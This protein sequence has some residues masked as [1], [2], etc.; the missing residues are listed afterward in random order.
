MNTPCLNLRI[1]DGSGSLENG[2]YYAVIAYTIKGEKISDY[3]AASNVQPVYTVNTAQGS[4]QL[5]VEADAEN[6]DEFQLVLVANINENTVARVIGYYS[7]NTRN[8]FIDQ[9]KPSFESIDI[10]LIPLVTPV[11]EKSD[12]I[13]QLNT[14]LLRVG[15]TSRFDFNY[16]PLAN[17]IETE[18]VSVEY[19]ANYYFKGGS[20]TN[21]MRD[22]VY[23]FFIRWVYNTGDKSAS[24]HIPGRAPE[25]W[26]PNGIPE[27]EPYSNSDSFP[28]DTLLFQT[29][30]T[31]RLNPAFVPYTLPDGGRVIAAGKMGYWQS[32]EK[33][34]DNRPDIWNSSSYVWTGTWDT[35]TG[36]PI[37]SL[38]YDLCGLPIRHHK[39][40]ENVI[41]NENT[42][43]LLIF[44]GAHH[45]AKDTVTKAIYIRMMSV[46]FKNIIYPKDNDGNDIPGIVGYE[47]LRGSRDGNRSII[48]KGMINNFRTYNRVG[49]PGNTRTGL[50]ANYPYNT[51][52]PIG[53]NNNP[54]DHNYLYNDP[55]IKSVDANNNFLDQK[56]PKN[57]ISFHSPDTS[58]RT[59]YLAPIELKIYGHLEGKALQRF[60]EP[61]GHPKF[62]LM[63]NDAL[64]II[65]LSGLGDALLRRAGKKQINYPL[66]SFENWY[67]LNWA[68]T[69]GSGGPAATFFDGL[70]LT[71]EL[72]NQYYQV[73][74]AATQPSRTAFFNYV[75]GGGSLGDYFLGTDGQATIA[76]SN[77]S[78]SGSLGGIRNSASYTVEQSGASLLP[79]WTDDLFN[80]LSTVT[81]SGFYFMEGAQAAQDLIQAFI[82]YRQYALQLIG[83]GLYDEFRPFNI[84]DTKRFKIADSSYVFKNIS[85]EID[86]YNDTIIG[87][88]FQK[89]TINNYKRGQLLMLRTERPNTP[90]TDG[91]KLLATGASGLDQSLGSL[92]MF[93]DT[94]GPD[95]P[96]INEKKKSIEFETRIA[97]HYGAMKID[98]DDQYGQLKTITQFPITPCEQKFDY[99][100]L[101]STSTPI[102]AI[103]V[104]V[105]Q[106]IITQ[107]PVIFGGDTYITRF[108]EKNPM[109]FFYNWLYTEPNGYEYNY[110]NSQMIPEPRYWANSEKYDV[111]QINITSIGAWAALFNNSVTGTG[112]LPNDYFNLDNENYVRTTDSPYPLGGGYPGFT[113]A[114]NS[115]FYLSASG[116]RD[117]FVESDVINDFREVGTFDYEKCYNPYRYTD[118]ETMFRMDKLTATEGNFYLYDYS[119]SITRLTNRYTSFGF[120][121]SVYYNP[122]VAELCYTYYPNTITYSLPVSQ[123]SSTDNWF[124]FLPLNRKDF[125]SQ[126]SGVKNFAKTGA[127]VTF[128]NDS[129]IVFQGVD[130]LE[131]DGSGTK[132]I[133]GDAGLFAR[134]PQN[135]VVADK[136]YMYGSSQGRLSVISTPAGLYYISQD[137]GKV[138]SY[139]EGLQEVSQ[140]GMKWW[141][142]YF[143]PSKLLEDFPDYPYTDNPVAGVGTQAVYDN[144][145]SVLYFC[146]KDYKLKE[147]GPDGFPLAGRVINING[148]KE[149]YF[150][151]Y[152]YIDGKPSNTP[153]KLALGDSRIFEDA[154][155]TVSYDPKSQFWI[156]FHDWH[157]DLVMPTKDSFITTKRNQFFK[158]GASCNDYC[159][160]YGVQYPF[161]IEFP[162][163]TG[164]TVTTVKS[165]EYVL[166]CYR[167]EQRYCTDQFHILDY[168]F[169]RLV[170]HNSEQIS[171]YL[172]LNVF[173]KNNIALSLLYPQLNVNNNSFDI[174]FSKEENKYRINQFWDITKDRGEFPNGSGYPPQ[175]Q[176]IPGTTT[177][178]GNY[179]E[180]MLWVT[181]ANGYKKAI[182]PQ[183]VDYNKSLLQ[184]KKFRHMVNFMYLSKTNSRDTNMILK[185]FNSKNQYSLR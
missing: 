173:P 73:W 26:G 133:I 128:K 147:I 88:A 32:T 125:V 3:F 83:H 156:S 184:R 2:S 60:I 90:T 126:I 74:S 7:T 22:E 137:Q 64:W 118:L 96:K 164:Q 127:F 109:F 51:I 84:N 12:Q 99:N 148:V 106:K 55:Y 177:L 179:P 101:P 167:R 67:G 25:A 183:A 43:Q 40:P 152:P 110:F 163:S 18:W 34:P 168:N 80:V 78:L 24:Y 162:I 54:G 108:T 11:F 10:T 35:V 145:N 50:Y 23:T 119:L 68:T 142:D 1:G 31:A 72:P 116:V 132:V 57:I 151:Y 8:I 44:N 166:E 63:T 79:S 71:S 97:S 87:S 85:F 4:L 122:E 169:D 94:L 107:T 98:N 16:Q 182:N 33:Y 66:G 70:N 62:K 77:N 9:Y 160:F 120:L 153:I 69:G 181:E 157:P 52:V 89:Y 121:Q 178:L 139:G 15:P 56:V 165:I 176:L 143:L 81:Q 53:N 134:D 123:T 111:S 17:L 58:F 21:F 159:N 174:L 59:P 114:K 47:I 171:G 41:Y 175:G 82:P 30:N 115:Y 29:I 49:V 144:Y 100:Q 172:N 75:A 112:F 135:I 19:P 105:K 6:F 149:S 131:M 48:A 154:S 136:P 124:I 14:Y 130:T 140:A 39:F 92:G 91:P 65:L 27:N 180:N 20:K 185:L 117:F 5:E 93:D 42:G 28:G 86:D 138:F 113:N 141:F 37:P 102:S 61:Q 155:W 104:V 46:Q 150:N 13:A 146:K 36:Q 170:V 129:P 76:N 38:A 161:E 95:G 103:N 158:H 45:F